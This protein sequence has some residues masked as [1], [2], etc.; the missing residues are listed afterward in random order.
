MRLRPAGFTLIEVIVVMAVL[1]ILAAISIPSYSEYVRRSKRSAAR[2]V[3]LEA[4]QY[5]ERNFTVAGC[6]DFANSSSC[7]GRGGTA[8]LIPAAM[9]R[10][11][12]EGAASYEVTWTFSDGGQAFLL[13]AIPC[14][15][16]GSCP[17][18]S[19]GG[20]TDPQCGRLSLS[21]TGLRGASAAANAAAIAVCWQR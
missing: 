5:L 10:A 1:A 3:L 11:P 12:S 8:V 4:A 9:Q 16:G 17:P 20:F 6:Y 19:D 13:T 15:A 14:G 7:V 2:T 21:N 18:G